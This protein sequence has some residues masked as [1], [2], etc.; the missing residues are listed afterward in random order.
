[1]QRAILAGLLVA[2]LTGVVGVFVSLRK[3][4][5]IAD[6]TAHASLLGVAIATLLS[7]QALLPAIIVGV[8][9]SVLV[10]F[11]KRRSKID[12]DSVIGLLFPFLFALAVIIISFDTGYRP[13]LTSYLFGNLLAINSNDIYIT[14]I[15]LVLILGFVIFKFK[16]LSLLA[17]SEE[18]AYT[19]GVRTAVYDY[20]FA[21]IVALTVIV[22]VKLAGVILVTSLLISPAVSAR[23]LSPNFRLLIPISVAHNIVSILI[24]LMFGINF[25]T[26]PAIV[27]VS[28]SLTGLVF[29]YSLLRR[30]N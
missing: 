21:V 17:I 5:F 24:G 15:I 2:V 7:T 10:T 27:V 6:S 19:R 23:L 8:C 13:E 20:I 14:V 1:M 22:A 30:R 28:T 26:G 16:Q 12:S 11:F 25:P 4:S 3:E 18:M 29:V 9:F